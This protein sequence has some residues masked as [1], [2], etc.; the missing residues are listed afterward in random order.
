[1]IHGD[2][3]IRQSE[4]RNS[5]GLGSSGFLFWV[6]MPVNVTSSIYSTEEFGLLSLIMI[7]SGEE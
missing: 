2:G 7:A 4:G 3:A 5:E 6:Q 1:M